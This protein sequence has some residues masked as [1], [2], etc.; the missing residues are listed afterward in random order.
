MSEATAFCL[1]LKGANKDKVFV[2]AA[3]RNAASVI[4]VLG[5]RPIN[6][7]VSSEADKLRDALLSED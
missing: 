7:Y 4:E 1:R 6:D 5:D 3:R 2:R